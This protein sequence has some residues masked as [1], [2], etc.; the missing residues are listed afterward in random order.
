M[1]NYHLDILGYDFNLQSPVYLTVAKLLLQ[2]WFIP[3]KC[4]TNA[5]TALN[6]YR[7]LSLY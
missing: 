6:S 3:V 2:N 7:Y 4:L 5:S 1:Q